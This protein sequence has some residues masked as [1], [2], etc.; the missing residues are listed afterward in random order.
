[1]LGAV[2]DMIVCTVSEKRGSYLHGSHS[3]NDFPNKKC[4][5]L[6]QARCSIK[7][8]DYEKRL[9][10]EESFNE[11]SETE[12]LLDDSGFLRMRGGMMEMG[13]LLDKK[14]TEG[15]DWD[16][17]NKRGAKGHLGEGERGNTR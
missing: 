3:G 13:T 5:F 4:R 15:E 16:V 10:C 12:R 17:I 1:M 7:F 11:I 6:N 2:I 14:D 8:L 9:G